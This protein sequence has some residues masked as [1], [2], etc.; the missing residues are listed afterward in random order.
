ME[1]KDL[2]RRLLQV[3][4]VER[5][6]IPEIFNH[7]W[8]RTYGTQSSYLSESYFA[9]TTAFAVQTPHHG[10]GISLFPSLAS[11]TPLTVKHLPPLAS[12]ATGSDAKRT[13]DDTTA[14]DQEEEEMSSPVVKVLRC[15]DTVY[16]PIY[17]SHHDHRLTTPSVAGSHR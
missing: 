10:N 15:D 5:A 7:M 6:S 8:M 2:M 17:S 4:P 16:I 13:D 3:D 12:M 9:A 1:S 14:V 11:S